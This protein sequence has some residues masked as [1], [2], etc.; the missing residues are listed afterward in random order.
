MSREIFDDFLAA[1]K[2]LVRLARQQLRIDE[3]S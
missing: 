1:T 3:A 2:D